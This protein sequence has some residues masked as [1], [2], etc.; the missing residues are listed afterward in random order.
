MRARPR[1]SALTHEQIT[2]A[3]RG[4]DGEVQP[5]SARETQN[6]PPSRT[7]SD[8]SREEANAAASKCRSAAQ[9]KDQ[10]RPVNVGVLEGGAD[11]V[12]VE[13]VSYPGTR[14]KNPR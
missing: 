13:E 14:W 11:A 10:K 3:D 6:R 8:A 7:R 1:G 9:W 12:V 2:N 5:G 4:G